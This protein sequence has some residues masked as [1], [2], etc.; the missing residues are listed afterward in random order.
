[1]QEETEE[2]VRRVFRVD[3]EE[4]PPYSPDLSYDVI[5]RIQRRPEWRREY[6]ALGDEGTVNQWIGK[7]VRALTN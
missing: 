4:P 2:L 6:E 3:F 5:R 1:M 7:A